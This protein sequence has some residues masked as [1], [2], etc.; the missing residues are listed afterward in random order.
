MIAPEVLGRAIGLDQYCLSIEELATVA[1]AL[2]AKP[3]YDNEYSAIGMKIWRDLMEINFD[4]ANAA[5]IDVRDAQESHLN[6]IVAIASEVSQHT[7]KK[8]NESL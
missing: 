8:E 4:R 3:Y 7:N 5:W 6:W 2:T 1:V